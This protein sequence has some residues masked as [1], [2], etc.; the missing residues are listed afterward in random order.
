MTFGKVQTSGGDN[1]LDIEQAKEHL[2]IDGADFDSDLAD[3][4]AEALA[5]CE[6]Q[7]GRQFKTAVWDLTFHRFPTGGRRQLLPLGN[8]Q[9]VDA[10]NYVDP[11]GTTQTITSGTIATDY[12]VDTAREPGSIA[13]IFG[14]TWPETRVQQTAVVYTIT[15]GQASA[16]LKPQA[17][18]LLKF[19][20][21]H[22]WWDRD[23]AEPTKRM[24]ELVTHLRFDDLVR[25][26]P[27]RAPEK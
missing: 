4:M 19:A 26:D 24:G 6:D 15:C 14:T 17:R 7:T 12:I 2:R 10:I 11:D 13:P 23:L 18:A 9:T 16:S 8:L 3:K 22:L 1:P 20:I 5:W 27:E 21:A 25:Y